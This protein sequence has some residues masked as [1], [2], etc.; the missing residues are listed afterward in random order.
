MQFSGCV[1]LFGLTGNV[2]V[3][4]HNLREKAAVITL[5]DNAYRT[6]TIRKTIEPAHETSI[7]LSLDH[8]HGWYDFTVRT[9][10]SDAEFRYA[11]RVETG[12]P[13]VS[14]PL[15]GGVV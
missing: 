3:H 5:S 15:M 2:L 11:G 4:L 9:D 1:V 12:K 6:K 8:S 7:I 13:S 14:D 10:A